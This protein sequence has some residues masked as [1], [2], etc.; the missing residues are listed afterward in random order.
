M[1]VHA[2]GASAARLPGDFVAAAKEELRRTARQLRD[3][4]DPERR[5][6][7]AESAATHLLA[8]PRL[9]GARRVAVFAAVSSELDA[10]QAI[11]GL[12]ARGV[13]LCYPR[14]VAGSRRLEFHLVGS[15][16]QLAPGAFAIPEPA[17]V[18][19]VVPV[20]AIDAFVVPGL[21][22]DAGGARI[23]W[24]R[25]FYDRS[26]A[27]APDRLRIGYCYDC[28]LFDLVP[29]EPSDLP[30]HIIVT[31]SGALEPGGGSPR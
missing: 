10:G 25:G 28:Q 4:I 18:A 15:E 8:L 2:S 3:A 6:R 26:L 16:D 19:P 9:A 17:A 12:R 29:R 7:A 23:G 27:A 21:A 24:G 5:L 1:S 13:E 14:V 20:A 22:F 11:R 31:E 30:M